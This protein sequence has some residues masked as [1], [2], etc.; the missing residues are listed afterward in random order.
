ML[1][2]K[3]EGLITEQPVIIFSTSS[4][5]MCHVMKQLLFSLGVNP[6]VHELDTQDKLAEFEK[7]L[8]NTAGGEVTIPVVFV[9]GK[10]IGSL[11]RLMSA[12][13]S[14]ELVPEL[15]KAGALW[16]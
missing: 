4:C 6:T 5:C 1:I 14:G 10:L 15:K 7:Y 13:I 11:D 2:E 8:A 12:H 9:G 3:I 16:L